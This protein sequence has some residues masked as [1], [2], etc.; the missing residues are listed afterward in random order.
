MTIKFI[1]LFTLAATLFLSACGKSD[2]DLQKAAEDRLAADKL[3]GVSV[4]VKEGVAVLTGDV[5]DELESA[6]MQSAIADISGIKAVVNQCTVRRSL[7]NPPPSA[8]L[9]QD[10]QPTQS[11]DPCANQSEATY[12]LKPDGGSMTFKDEASEQAYKDCI[13]WM[14]KKLLEAKKKKAQK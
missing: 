6:N 2:A 10:T 8:Q 12:Q 13:Q 4:V 9:A 11:S 14:G 3:T 1:T 5:F 7:M